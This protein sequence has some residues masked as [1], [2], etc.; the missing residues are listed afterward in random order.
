[1]KDAILI[2]LV[3]FAEGEKQIE[4]DITLLVGGFLI[5]GFVISRDDYMKHHATT[6]ALWKAIE[7]LPEPEDNTPNYIHLRNARYYASDG[8]PIPQNTGGY[9][10]ISL[11][12]IDGFSFGLLSADEC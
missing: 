2:A 10:R 4:H 1:M 11:E 12:S 6:N 5:S 8:N 7:D 9:I 3:N